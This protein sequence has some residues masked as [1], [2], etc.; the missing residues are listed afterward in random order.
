MAPVRGF[1]DLH[2]HPVAHRGFGGKV[3]VGEPW[4]SAGVHEA[5]KNCE[6]AGAGHS[7]FTSAQ[8]LLSWFVRHFSEGHGACG[9]PTFEHW[10]AYTTMYHQQMYVD[11]IRRSHAHGLRLMCALAVNNELLART[12]AAVRYSDYNMIESQVRALNEFV[13][14]VRAASTAAG[15]APWLDI[16]ESPAEARAIIGRGELAIV[17]G[18]E[19]DTLDSI[20]RHGDFDEPTHL[21][22]GPSVPTRDLR[23]RPLEPSEV[24]VVLD[25][26]QAWGISMIT[27]IHLADNSFGGAAIYDDRF[28]LLQEWLRG[29][30]YEEVVTRSVAFRLGTSDPLQRTVMRTIAQLKGARTYRPASSGRGHRN[31]ATLTAVGRR[32]LEGAMKRGFIL[33]VDHMS[34]KTTDASLSLATAHRYPV[35]SSHSSF[36][37]LGYRRHERPDELGLTHEA[38]KTPEQL[39]AILSL[40]GVVAPITNQHRCKAHG[41]TVANGI[42]TSRA[43]AQSFLYAVERAQTLGRGGVAFGTDFNGLAQQP[44]PRFPAEDSSNDSRRLRYGASTFFTGQPLLHDVLAGRARPFDLNEDGLAHYGLLGDFIEDLR[45]IQVPDAAIDT[46]FD[47]A[48]AFLQMWEAC[49]LRAAGLRRNEPIAEVV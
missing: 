28:D 22:A 1:A 31:G 14:N 4:N 41:S 29:L 36:R 18:V 11:F 7:P 6:G 20:A 42:G 27:P 38:M 23:A 40:G 39:D 2:T 45:T 15:E 46:L 26:L 19:V 5:L 43:Y 47:S 10:P 37:A 24:E 3:L 34:E 32:F 8:A 30:P 12:A 48:E 17:R 16:A 13:R 21:S 44:G 35:I 49:E 33:D 25:Q 9:A